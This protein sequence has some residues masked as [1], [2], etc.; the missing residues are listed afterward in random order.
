MVWFDKKN[1]YDDEVKVYKPAAWRYPRDV[2]DYETKVRGAMK[3]RLFLS[4]L[5]WGVLAVLWFL[6]KAIAVTIAVVSVI[7]LIFLLA[8]AFSKGPKVDGN[9]DKHGVAN[10]AK[11]MIT[12][13][14]GS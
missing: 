1:V 4:Q 13:R 5:G 10:G 3:L 9:L 6:C 11:A 14:Y 12:N 8:G 7:G 2:E